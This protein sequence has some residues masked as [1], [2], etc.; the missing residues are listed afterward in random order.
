MA[1]R[2]FGF[3]FG[4]SV[5]SSFKDLGREMGGSREPN[6]SSEFEARPPKTDQFHSSNNFPQGNPPVS[7]MSQGKEKFFRGKV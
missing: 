7:P 2:L 3:D 6:Q 1:F 5:E 4:N